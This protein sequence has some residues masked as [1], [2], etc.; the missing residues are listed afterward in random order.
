MTKSRCYTGASFSS[1]ALEEAKAE[2]RLCRLMCGRPLSLPAQHVNLCLG[3][4]PSLL[5]RSPAQILI[6]IGK[7]KPF[8]T[9]GG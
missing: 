9:S 3:F 5:G 6:L 8:R 7:A 1:C 4:A 2:S